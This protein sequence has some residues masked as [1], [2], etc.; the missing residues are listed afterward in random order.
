MLNTSNGGGPVIKVVAKLNENK[1]LK[2]S[3]FE[4]TKKLHA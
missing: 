2:I 4:F 1:E 3:V